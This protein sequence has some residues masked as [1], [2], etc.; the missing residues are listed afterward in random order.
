MGRQC[1]QSPWAEC[2]YPLKRACTL[3][4]WAHPHHTGWVP[5]FSP[6]LWQP[7]L[8]R[9]LLPITHTVGQVCGLLWQV[10]CPPHAVPVFSH[11]CGKWREQLYL[12]RGGWGGT[13]QT[14]HE[15]GTPWIMQ[16]FTY[17]T[18]WMTITHNNSTSNFYIMRPNNIHHSVLIYRYTCN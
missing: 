2:T 17:F 7:S 16:R 8:Q 4:S 12:Q 18:S 6:A 3:S 1:S 5:P 11:V 15:E 9:R 10:P 14:S 13:D